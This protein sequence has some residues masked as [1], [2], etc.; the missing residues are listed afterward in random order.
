MNT[1]TNV[2]HLRQPEELEDTSVAVRCRNPCLSGRLRRPRP[3]RW[4]TEP[5]SDVA[6]RSAERRACAHRAMVI[7]RHPGLVDRLE[8]RPPFP[9]CQYMGILLKWLSHA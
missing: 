5:T 3:G 6:F 9:K 7:A 4:S 8:L 2:V 1:S